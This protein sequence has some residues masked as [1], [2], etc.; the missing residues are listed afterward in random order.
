MELIKC[1]VMFLACMNVMFFSCVGVGISISQYSNRVIHLKKWGDMRGVKVDFPNNFDNLQP[2][3]RYTGIKFGSLKGA[4]GRMF[5]FFQPTGFM[6]PWEGTRD[7][8]DFAPVCKQDGVGFN[9]SLSPGPTR[10]F[11]KVL[12]HLKRQQEDCLFLNLW[13]P[14]PGKAFTF[15]FKLIHFKL[16]IIRLEQ[17]KCSSSLYV[18]MRYTNYSIQH[19]RT[20]S[21]QNIQKERKH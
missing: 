8:S 21:K 4:A 18:Y 7:F 20:K 15:F 19:K 5:T 14:I 12:E 10:K 16:F 1:L 6:P 2:I 3:E 9:A 17:N 13:S 11:M